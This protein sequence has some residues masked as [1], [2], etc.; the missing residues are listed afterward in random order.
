M[1]ETTVNLRF[2]ILRC[3]E[4]VS[5]FCKYD[6]S[7]SNYDSQPV[8]QDNVLRAEEIK[9]SHKMGARFPNTLIT[10]LIG[11]SNII[12]KALSQISPTLS[13]LDAY[14]QIPWEAL[15]ELFKACVIPRMGEA[16]IT[17]I[18]HKKRPQLIPILD[19]VVVQKYLEPLL[20]ANTDIPKEL[21]KK[22][23]LHI[24]QLKQDAES[25]RAILVNLAE[26]FNLPM[27]RILDIL[28][29][30][31]FSRPEWWV[32]D[33]IHKRVEA[34]VH[35]PQTTAFRQKL[36]IPNKALETAKKHY[37]KQPFSGLE[38]YKTTVQEYGDINRDSFLI[39]DWTVN[40]I[41]GYKKGQRD[42][43]YRL[44]FKRHDGLFESY[45][46]NVHGTWT[47]INNEC[48][49]ID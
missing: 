21:E 2:P 42:K 8:L 32:P 31:Y 38:L 10:E 36:S 16:N 15:E 48:R 35:Y 9:L 7:Y 14:E 24:K 49:R 46:Q 26:R 17:K 47:R 45:D 44:F 3:D 27:V 29:W 43:R 28:I 13:I 12:S 5:K 19:S 22:M 25:N 11:R 34:Y 37:G 40:E 23:V 1:T 30:T 18:L 4:V 39:A 20:T 6:S 41:S 33:E